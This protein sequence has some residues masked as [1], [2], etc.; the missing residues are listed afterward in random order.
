MQGTPLKT[1]PG[2]AATA[3]LIGRVRAI[4]EGI[5]APTHRR[6]FL[7]QVAVHGI[8]GGH[9]KQAPTQTRLVGGQHHMKTRVVQ[10]ADRLQRPG[11]GLPLFRRFD[12]LVARA[13][14]GAVAVEDDE[15]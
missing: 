5:D 4:E 12:E 11:Q 13:V 10:A 1:R 14:D 6:Q 3:A 2:F 15:F 8:E 7:D 9:V